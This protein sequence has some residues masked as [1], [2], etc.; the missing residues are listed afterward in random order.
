MDILHTIY[1]LSCDAQWT[2]QCPPFLGHVVIEW[3]LRSFE[4]KMA[5]G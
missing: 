4:E 3:P 2:F 1:P 5:M